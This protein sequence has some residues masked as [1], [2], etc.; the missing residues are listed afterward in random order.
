MIPKIID[1]AEK[2]WNSLANK[3]LPQID[4]PKVNFTFFPTTKD[5][6]KYQIRPFKENENW[7]A[8]WYGFISNFSNIKEEIVFY[9]SWHNKDIKLF[10][11]IPH[12]LKNYFENTFYASFPTSELIFLWD[13]KF[14]NNY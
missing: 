4:L 1:L 11:L 3:S 13:V 6:L 14:K 12:K 7:S 10:V 9:T 2:I 8:F 5:F